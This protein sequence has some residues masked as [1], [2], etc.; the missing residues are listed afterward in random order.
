MSEIDVSTP[1]GEGTKGTV[2]ASAVARE[3][4]GR[5]PEETS[6]S[7]QGKVSEPRRDVIDSISL[8]GWVGVELVQAVQTIE[9]VAF[10]S[11]G[12]QAFA[13][14]SGDQGGNLN[15]GANGTVATSKE[16]RI[17]GTPSLPKSTHPAG[18]NDVLNDQDGYRGVFGAEVDKQNGWLFA[19]RM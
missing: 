2:L 4:M 3:M 5:T 8:S 1:A 10:N 11:R 7:E 19:P 17:G 13:S 14:L 12:N 6:S 18:K 15:P 9:T 16:S